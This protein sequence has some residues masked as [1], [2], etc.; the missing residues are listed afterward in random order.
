MKVQQAGL[1][2]N[3]HF[4]YLTTATVRIYELAW[5]FVSNQ[6]ERSALF[7]AHKV[8]SRREH[9]QLASKAIINNY[10]VQ[11]LVSNGTNGC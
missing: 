6:S 5:I 10:T 7:E 11:W 4:F 3:S 1:C 2:L 8:S 9:D